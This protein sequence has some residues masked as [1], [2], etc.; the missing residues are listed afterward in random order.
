[1]PLSTLLCTK[2]KTPGI[3]AGQP[4]LGLLQATEALRITPADLL[5]FKVMDESIP[6]P[7]GAAHTDPMAAFP[8]I[9]EAIMR[10]YHRWVG[11]WVGW[12]GGLG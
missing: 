6:E 8:A 12:Q 5:R 11:G 3:C 2:N 7:L 1:M 10:N 4:T 9:K